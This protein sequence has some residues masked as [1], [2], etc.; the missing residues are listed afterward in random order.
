MPYAAT[1]G[2]RKGRKKETTNNRRLEIAITQNFETSVKK[3]VEMPYS[4][5]GLLAALFITCHLDV[6]QHGNEVVVSQS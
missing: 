4:V 1:P 2:H 3:A 6:I 5:F